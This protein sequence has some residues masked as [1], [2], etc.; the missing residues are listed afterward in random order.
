MIKVSILYPYAEG[1]RFDMA[2][3]VDTHMPMAVELL[4]PGM[5]GVSVEEGLS[6]AMPGSTPPYAAACHFLFDT[7]EAFYDAFLPH[8]DTLQGDIPNYTDI[9]PIIHFGTVRLAR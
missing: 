6:G 5:K 2:Y 7:A 4:G 9:T 8:A 3:Y 1:A